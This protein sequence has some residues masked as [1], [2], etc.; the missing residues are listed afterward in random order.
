[1]LFSLKE[2]HTLCNAQLLPSNYH[3]ILDDF[4]STRFQL[5]DNFTISTTPKIKIILDH[6]EDYLDDCEVTLVK[7]TDEL[8]ENIHQ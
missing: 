1:V 7:T 5:K 6:I 4:K 3:K 8:C 2:V